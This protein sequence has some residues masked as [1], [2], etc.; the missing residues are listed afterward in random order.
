M[1]TNAMTLARHVMAAGAMM[2]GVSG[3]A[4]AG[5]MLPG[6]S[7]NSCY[8]TNFLTVRGWFAD[9][10]VTADGMVLP[11]DSTAFPIKNSDCDFYAWSAQMFLWLTSPVQ[12]KTE[13]NT[14]ASTFV[15]DGPG[16]YDV[17]SANSSGQRIL[18]P[19][20]SVLDNFAIRVNKTDDDLPTGVGETGQAGGAA[21]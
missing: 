4:Q 6:Q 9:G 20:T 10:K 15:F 5:D 17:S 3:M 14:L 19:N 11:A 1:K 16:F 13:N 7:A 21:C 2:L 8:E 12:L 18:L